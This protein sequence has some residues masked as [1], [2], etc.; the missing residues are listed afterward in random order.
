MN[1]VYIIIDGGYAD[2]ANKMLGTLGRYCN[3][4]LLFYGVGIGRELQTWLERRFGKAFYASYNVEEGEWLGRRMLCKLEKLATTEFKEGDRVFVLDCDLILQDDIFV[5]FDQYEE[6]VLYTTRGYKSLAPI[7]SGVWGFRYNSRVQEFLDFFV[8][9]IRKPTWD[10]FLMVANCLKV[11][12]V[13]LPTLALHTIVALA[14]Q[15]RYWQTSGIR[16]TR[17]CTSKDLI[18]HFSMGSMLIRN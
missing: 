18:N 12:R 15:K 17:Y 2:L 6:D 11:W 7:N 3:C 1:F 13:L 14:T 16:H 5:A 9:Q 10:K 4:E 8:A